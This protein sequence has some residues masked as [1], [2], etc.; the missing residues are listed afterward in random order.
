MHAPR[1]LTATLG[2][3]LG[4]I[5]LTSLTRANAQY[6][7]YGNQMMQA[8]KYDEAIKY[9]G[10]AAK[11]E[12]QNALAY[13][14]LG[15]ASMAKRDLGN[16]LKY[17]EY[18]L[19]LDPQDQGLRKYLGQT[20]Q[21]YGNQYYKSGNKAAAIQWWEKAIATDPS[22]LQLTEYVASLKASNVPSQVPM[23]N[24]APVAQTGSTEAPEPPMNPWVM[25][26]S[27]AT[28]GAIMLFLF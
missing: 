18:S 2:L 5:I 26:G 9:F 4:L 20:Y 24:P 13:K 27:V 19:R 25:G 10:A 6:I 22:N 12:P 21:S 1:N 8:Q 28:V 7:Q 23:N 16:G 3:F 17:M 15:Y 11:A 14:G